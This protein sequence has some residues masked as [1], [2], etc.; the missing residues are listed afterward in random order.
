MP[1]RL[2]DHVNERGDNPISEWTRSLEKKERAKLAQK[3]DKLKQ[4]GPELFPELLTGTDTPGVL[5]LRVK[6]NVQLRP[7][8]C[9]GPVDVKSEFTL[10][11]GAIEVGGKLQPRGADALAND[12]KQAIK[13]DPA[14]RRK[15]H[16]HIR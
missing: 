10:L 14:N 9:E 5:K 15:E 6:G 16:E 4:H 11:L 13:A 1:F 7:M 12:I 2:Y 3:L 8:L